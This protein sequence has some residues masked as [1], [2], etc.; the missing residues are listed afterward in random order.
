M[1]I[2]Y[3]YDNPEETALL[4][5]EKLKSFFSELGLPTSL[6]EIDVKEEPEFQKLL[7]LYNPEDYVVLNE[8]AQWAL[9]TEQG[10]VLI[11]NNEH[12]NIG[13]VELP[14]LERIDG[15]NEVLIF[16]EPVTGSIN[17]LLMEYGE[18]NRD[19]QMYHGGFSYFLIL[20]KH[21]LLDLFHCIK[22]EGYR[23]IIA[24]G[25]MYSGEIW[26]LKE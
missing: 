6:S 5:I 1:G 24:T 14:V 3:N 18:E 22:T 12:L 17:A 4:G 15:M 16:V 21:K 7:T 23:L 19:D 13:S 9:A 2:E 26:L 25:L 8:I 11:T 10:T 20:P